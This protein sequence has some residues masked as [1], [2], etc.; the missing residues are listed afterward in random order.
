MCCLSMA[1]LAS[2]EAPQVLR[3]DV[4]QAVQLVFQLAYLA[5]ALHEHHRSLKCVLSCAD[6]AALTREPHSQ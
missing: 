6:A 5:T 3:A 1:K 2:A 4:P